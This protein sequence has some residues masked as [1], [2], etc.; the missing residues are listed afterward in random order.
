[1]VPL[2]TEWKRVKL[3]VED[4]L[5]LDAAGAL[6]AYGRTELIDGEIVYVNAQHRPHARVKSRLFRL[7]ANALDE[8]GDGSEAIVEGS[9]AM[10]PHNVPEPDIAVTREAEG[11]GLIPL[12][13]VTLVVEV[14]DTTLAEDLGRKMLTY[15]R[16][17]VPEYWVVDVNGRVIHQMWSPASDGYVERREV[18]FGAAITAA[19]LPG[20]TIETASLG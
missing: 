10:P 15:A 16:D 11:D 7:I 20:L 9:V 12:G 19:T 3:R 2:T 4:Y 5:T 1:M 17:A 8:I 18:A 14:A 13:S 6:D